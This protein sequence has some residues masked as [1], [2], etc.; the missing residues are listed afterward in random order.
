MI[1][2]HYCSQCK[3]FYYLNGHKASCPKCKAALMELPISYVRFLSLSPKEQ[4]SYLQEATN[5]TK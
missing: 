1:Y 2:I 3:K 4:L 5:C